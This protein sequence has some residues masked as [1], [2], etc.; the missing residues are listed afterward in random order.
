MKKHIAETELALFA[1]GELNVTARVRVGWHVRG[2]ER[3]AGRVEAYRGDRAAV[4]E[5]VLE[6]PA[7]VDWDRL[8]RE[9][10]GNIRVGLAAGE[11]VAVK[12]AS[13]KNSFWLPAGIGAGAMALLTVAWVLNVPSS[14]NDS[15]LRSTRAIFSKH[16]RGAILAVSPAGVEV[17][18]GGRTLNITEG[19]VRPV[20]YTVD[21]AGSASARYVD[22]DNGQVTIASVYV[23]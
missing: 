20:A 21:V 10:T 3:C 1:S 2:C 12:P 19:V 17:H 22:A 15:L 5:E 23:E 4:R 14:D 6:M 16:E 7:G 8:S 13:R 18:D 11:C 9:M